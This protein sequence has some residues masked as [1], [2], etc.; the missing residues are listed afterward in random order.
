[1]SER[2]QISNQLATW[3]HKT[4]AGASTNEVFCEPLRKKYLLR[5]TGLLLTTQGS[6]NNLSYLRAARLAMAISCRLVSEIPNLD[7]YGRVWHLID[8]GGSAN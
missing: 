3:A 6:V 2:E 1:M 5:R 8:T 4:A 7:N